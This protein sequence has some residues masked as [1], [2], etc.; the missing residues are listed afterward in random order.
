MLRLLFLLC[1]T[2]LCSRANTS[3]LDIIQ[4]IFDD[5]TGVVADMIESDS[6]DDDLPYCSG[7]SF[8]TQIE[9]VCQPLP[10]EEESAFIGLLGRRRRLDTASPALVACLAPS[11]EKIHEECVDVIAAGV[12][13][14]ST[15]VFEGV[16]A[17]AEQAVHYYCC[18]LR[19][20][21]PEEVYEIGFQYHKLCASASHLFQEGTKSWLGILATYCPNNLSPYLPSK[22]DRSESLFALTGVERNPGMPLSNCK[23]TSQGEGT[24]TI[25]FPE[26][27]SQ[28]D[29]AHVPGFI[30]ED[31]TEES[32]IS[33]VPVAGEECPTIDFYAVEGMLGEF[34]KV[35]SL[36]AARGFVIE[37]LNEQAMLDKKAQLAQNYKTYDIIRNNCS[38]KMLRILA[39]GMGCDAEIIPFYIPSALGKVLENMDNSNEVFGDDLRSIETKIDS[40]LQA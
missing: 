7:K 26:A 25:L 33:W 36:K 4:G 37:G 2:F 19:Q 16:E 15:A 39:A 40:F 6:A 29:I 13:Q 31:V 11:N 14:F 30:G 34:G 8:A 35:Y 38:H 9:G 3:L 5:L 1:S 12:P 10:A 18:V 28:S 23:P 32:W 20:S 21:E 17:W 22:D 24:L 27:Q